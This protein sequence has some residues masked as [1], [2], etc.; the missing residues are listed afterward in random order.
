MDK[1]VFPVSR[2]FWKIAQRL[3][4][5]ELQRENIS[6]DLVEED[7]FNLNIGKR[8]HNLFLGFYSKAGL[9]LVLK[10]YSIYSA[11]AKK[12]YKDIMID[13]DVSDPYKHCLRIFFNKKSDDTKLA[14]I[15]VRRDAVSVDVPF[16]TTLKGKKM[17]SLIIEW[18]L[19]QSPN[20]PFPKERPA[21][22]GQKYPGLGLSPKILE[23]LAIAVWRLG[24]KGIINIP[25]HYHNAA[26]YS[27]IFHYEN[28]AD[29]AKLEAIIRDT[30]EYPLHVVAWAVELGGLRDVRNDKIFEWFVSKQVLP[31]S[32]AW[33]QVFRSKEYRNRVKLLKNEYEFELDANWLKR[34]FNEDQ[35]KPN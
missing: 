6:I 13:M 5:N 2:K 26:L 3:T 32:R 22:P 30:R 20:K 16:D 21:L 9:E 14:E 15:V 7:F 29:Q 10:K 23:L 28:P 1:A 18:L 8:G 17:E 19:L 31:L 4:F 25:D 34:R 12:G 24:M 27:R 11:L 33:L 35:S